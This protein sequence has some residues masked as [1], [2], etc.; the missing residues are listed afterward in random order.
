METN[1]ATDE[2]PLKDCAA[3]YVRQ[4][5]A[6]DDEV[7]LVLMKEYAEKAYRAGWRSALEKIASI[8]GDMK[9]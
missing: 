3:E 2:K 1:V 5:R 8:A 4:I 6:A 7:A 9:R